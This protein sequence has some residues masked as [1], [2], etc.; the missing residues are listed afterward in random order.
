MDGIVNDDNRIIGEFIK[1][2]EE[3][4]ESLWEQD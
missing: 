1:K 2:C 3:I 4:V